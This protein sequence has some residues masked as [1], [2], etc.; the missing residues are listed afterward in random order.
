MKDSKAEAEKSQ[1][2]IQGAK[3]IAAGKTFFIQ[4]KHVE[5]AFLLLTRILSSPGAF[6]NLPRS[7]L[8]AAQFY[9]AKEGELNREAV[10]V[11]VCWGQTPNASE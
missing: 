10:L 1:Q 11:P 8:D 2:E 3:K 4:S 5:E 6:A 7:V 9:R